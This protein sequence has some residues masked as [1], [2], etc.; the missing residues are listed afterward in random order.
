[1][2]RRAE[3]PIAGLRNLG[4]KSAILLREAGIATVEELRELGAVKAYRRVKALRPKGASLNLLWAMAAGL[5]GR[6]WRALSP[7]EKAELSRE[8]KDLRP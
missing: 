2:K 5:D 4:P 7:D 1:M 8:V 3:T 6:D